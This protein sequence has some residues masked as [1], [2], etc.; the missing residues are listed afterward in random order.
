[1]VN[2]LN[3][4]LNNQL[5]NQLNLQLS[6]Q[7]N[8]KLSHQL[9]DKLNNQLNGWKTIVHAESSSCHLLQAHAHL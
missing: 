1:M 9:K 6:D 7:L 4:H 8:D 2:Q 3:K 5:K